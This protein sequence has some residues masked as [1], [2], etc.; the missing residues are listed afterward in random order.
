[1]AQVAKSVVVSRPTLTLPGARVTLQA[2]VI[3]PKS[4]GNVIVRSLV[5]CIGRL[6]GT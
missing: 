3:A 5:Y 6:P 4:H 1:M 2:V